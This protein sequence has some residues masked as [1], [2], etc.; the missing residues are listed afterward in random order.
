MNR[1]KKYAVV[2]SL[3]VCKLD[4]KIQ[5]FLSKNL[6]FKILPH[7]R[8]LYLRWTR[9]L[10]YSTVKSPR[11]LSTL[12]NLQVTWND[13]KQDKWVGETLYRIFV[14]GDENSR[15]RLVN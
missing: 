8:S 11:V 2:T 3:L 15:L 14:G 13:I 6:L 12:D 4:S 9:K 7:S 1:L 10:G 5:I